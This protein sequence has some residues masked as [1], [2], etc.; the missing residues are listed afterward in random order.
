[1]ETSFEYI[2]S[3]LLEDYDNNPNQN[4]NVLIEKHAQKM[5]LSEE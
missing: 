5:G 1:M 3:S 4:I 2:L